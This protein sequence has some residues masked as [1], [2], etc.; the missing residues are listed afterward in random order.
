[1]FGQVGTCSC[2]GSD[3]TDEDGSLWMPTGANIMK[4][5]NQMVDQAEHSDKFIP[6]QSVLQHLSSLTNIN[7]PDTGILPH[8]CWRFLDLLPA[9][10]FDC[11]DQTLTSSPNFAPCH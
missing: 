5:L 10:C 2:Y 4:A 3:L 9:L 1:M 8:T 7:T 11:L 6:I